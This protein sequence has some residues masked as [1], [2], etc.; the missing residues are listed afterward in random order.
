MN[1][2]HIYG[3]WGMGHGAWGMGQGF[4]NLKVGAWGMGHCSVSHA[5]F[6]IA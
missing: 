6:P 2:Q 3:E 5:S 1:G 4:A